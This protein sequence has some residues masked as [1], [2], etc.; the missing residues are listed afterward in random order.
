[1]IKSSLRRL[2]QHVTTNQTHLLLSSWSRRTWSSRS[3]ALLPLGDNAGWT[4]STL[5]AKFNSEGSCVAISILLPHKFF[6]CTHKCDG[7]FVG[8]LKLK[9][10]PLGHLALARSHIEL[11]LHDLADVN[12]ESSNFWLT[13]ALADVIKHFTRE[14][15]TVET[16]CRQLCSEGDGS[17]DIGTWSCVSGLRTNVA[18]CEGSVWWQQTLGVEFHESFSDWDQAKRLELSHSESMDVDRVISDTDVLGELHV[19]R[20]ASFKLCVAVYSGKRCKHIALCWSVF[21]ETRFKRVP[22]W[23]GRRVK[24]WVIVC[25]IDDGLIGKFDDC[26][27]QKVILTIHDSAITVK[28]IQNDWRSA[29]QLPVLSIEIACFKENGV[30][31][32]FDSVCN[33]FF[34]FKIPH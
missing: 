8:F 30:Q 34:V 6:R 19:L 21:L 9:F 10:D 18:Y 13:C 14:R 31:T 3:F 5:A 23:L 7:L 33:D 25:Q 11:V 2:G 32:V 17:V 29:L 27:S 28:N 16:V 12:R 15:R 4:L 22:F 1:M 26:S 20:V 24:V